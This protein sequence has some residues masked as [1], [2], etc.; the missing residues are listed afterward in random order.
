MP[1]FRKIKL[2]KKDYLK[3]GART[4]YNMMNKIIGEYFKLALEDALKGNIVRLLTKRESY[5][6]IRTMNNKELN[7]N[8]K[9]YAEFYNESIFNSSFPGLKIMISQYKNN[10]FQQLNH[11]VITLAD[12]TERMKESDYDYIQEFRN[13]DIKKSNKLK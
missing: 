3:Y 12:F 7:K 1:Y 13:M 10:N 11:Q 8:L 6:Y 2:V 5:L 4:K 9:R